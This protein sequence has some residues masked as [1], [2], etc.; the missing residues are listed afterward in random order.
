LGQETDKTVNKPKRIKGFVD[1]HELMEFLTCLVVGTTNV[2]DCA[3]SEYHTVIVTEQGHL[4]VCGID[5]SKRTA[6]EKDFKFGAILTHILYRWTTRHRFEYNASALNT[7]A[8]ADVASR[9]SSSMLEQ[10][11]NGIA[12]RR[13][14][15]C[16]WRRRRRA[17]G[18]GRCGAALWRADACRGRVARC[19]CAGWFVFI[20]VVVVVVCVT[21][22]VD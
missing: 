8:I 21:A 9:A 6:D 11:H 10:P 14:N 5:S 13:R 16:V 20:C 1:G 15:V 12:Q 18:V 3:T 7:N 17:A 22:S 2:I 19:C 4:L